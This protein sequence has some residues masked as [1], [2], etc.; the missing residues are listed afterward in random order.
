M[1]S[2]VKWMDNTPLILKIIFALPGID[3]IWAI[4]RLVKGIAHKNVALIVAGILWIVLGW[5]ILWIIDL[6]CIIIYKKPTLFA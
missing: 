4:Y 1:K 3:I 6:I 5:A 2:L